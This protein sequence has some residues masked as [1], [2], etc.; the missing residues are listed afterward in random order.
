MAGGGLDCCR[1]LED[2]LKP[3]LQLY[4]LRLREV[5]KVELDFD[6]PRILVKAAP[7]WARSLHLDASPDGVEVVIALS[8]PKG[9]DPG[10]VEARITR[11]LEESEAYA[12]IEDYDIAYEP[13]QGELIVTLYSRLLR[14][15]PGREAIEAIRAALEAG[16]SNR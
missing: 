11:L 9:L 14:G 6:G 4:R 3:V 16:E 15:Q 13:G 10:Q 8:A 12:S 1:L 7:G 2:A 5:S